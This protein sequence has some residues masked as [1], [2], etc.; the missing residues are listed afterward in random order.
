MKRL[1]NTALILALALALAGCGAPT[2]AREVRVE[3]PTITVIKPL[4]RDAINSVALPGDLVGYY[5]VALHSKVTGYLESIPVD[6]GDWVK[7]GQSLAVIEVPELA[8]NLERAKA[9]LEIKRVTYRRLK[10]VHDRDPRLVAQEDVDIAYSGMAQARAAVGELEVMVSYTRISAPFNGVITGRFVDPGALIRAGG[11]DFGVSGNGVAISAG[12]AEGAGGHLGGGGPLL[13]MSRIDKLRCYV[14][15][16]EEEAALIRVG[17]P[18]VIEVRGL[19]GRTFAAR[20]ARYAT[21]LDVATRT[22]LTEIDLDNPQHELYPRMYA[23]VKLELVRHPRAIELPAQSVEG[24]GANRGFVFTVE[25]NS[26]VKVPVTMGI[27]NGRFVEIT[28]GL[29]GSETVVSTISPALNEGEKIRP[30]FTVAANSGAGRPQV[31]AGK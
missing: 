5:E 24:I 4:R 6:K 27:T 17:T 22:M 26:L 8:Q 30:V 31:A 29:A 15:V 3:I 16:P 7:K 11:G 21:S 20:V 23:S 12:A 2:R 14:Y 18:A 10:K 9:N 25:N 28:S 1:R 13:T 19:R